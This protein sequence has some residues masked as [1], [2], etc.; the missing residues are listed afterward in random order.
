MI[1][2]GMSACSKA[3]SPE[4]IAA[5]KAV[6]TA[7]CAL[8]HDASPAMAR[9][10]GPPLFGVVG[11][12]IGGAVGFDYSSALKTAHARGEKWNESS[13]DAFLAD[14]QTAMPGSKMPVNVPDPT[15]RRNLIAYLT[16]LKGKTT[17]KPS[18]KGDNASADSLDWRKDAPGVVHK[19]TVAGLPKP[20]A[21]QSAGNGAQFVRP[22]ADFL[23]KVPAGFV[24]SSFSQG[25]DGPRNL[26]TAPNGDLYVVESSR[27]R[28]SVFR[29]HG[30][31]LDTQR[32]TFAEGLDQPFGI[33]F[34]NGYAYVANVGSV[35]RI[36]LAGGAK[37]T[38]VARL[39]TTGGH[40]TRDI[41]FSRDGQ[42]MYV[43]VGSASNVA[44][45]IGRPPQG[46]VAGHALGESWGSEAGRALVLR[47]RIDGSERHIVATGI[48][49]C[50]GLVMRPGSDDL[51]CTTNERDALG[52][53]LVPDYF[54]RVSEGQ[55]FGWPWYYL[56]DH[57][58]PR[59]AGIRPDLKGRVSVPDTLF[60]SHSAPL[61]FAF[62]QAPAG[63]ASAFPAAYNG[64]TFIALHG[65][66]N[67]SART[68]SKVVMVR[69]SGGKPMGEYEDFLTGFILDDQRVSGRPVGVAV[70]P[71][72]ALYVSDDAGDRIWR[73][74]PKP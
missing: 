15:E 40:S 55:F 9:L 54:T 29:N 17:I 34:L 44:E 20:F 43:S 57:E 62:Y 72:G 68:G 12:T 61:G 41:V 47:F 18:M 64:V 50:V 5:G 60:V 31:K 67:R 66:W 4:Q 53:N 23:P 45:G 49:N 33:A 71:D 25:V 1:L 11:R 52:D 26:R 13:L 63:A 69:L 46:F 32:Q 19:V 73:V 30:G 24:V 16:S 51:Y 58:D 7:N 70:G 36:P 6:F 27:G 38:V 56:G 2:S 8:C 48:R 14:P 21:T 42:Y 59:Q 10:Q 35:V 37:E 3:A 65:S 22:A 74:A 39:S 28:I